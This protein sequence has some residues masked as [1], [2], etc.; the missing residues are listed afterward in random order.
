MYIWLESGIIYLIN[1]SSTLHLQLLGLFPNVA[2][3]D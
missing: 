1:P 3:A 2:A